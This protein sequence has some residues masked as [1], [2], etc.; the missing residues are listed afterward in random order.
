MRLRKQYLPS[1]ASLCLTV[2]MT[3]THTAAQ[4]E[5]ILFNFDASHGDI[6]QNPTGGLISDAAGNLYGVAYFGRHLENGGFGPGSVFEG[7]PTGNGGW[8]TKPIYV[9]QSGTDGNVHSVDSSW[10]HPETFTE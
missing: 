4:Q 3:V 6:G 9:F 10:M 2:L 1:L 7:S 5:K 8:T